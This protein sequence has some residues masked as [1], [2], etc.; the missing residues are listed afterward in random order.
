MQIIPVV[1]SKTNKQKSQPDGVRP[2]VLEKEKFCY[3]EVVSKVRV[4]R[5]L[6]KDAFLPSHLSVGWESEVGPGDRSQ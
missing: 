5:R 3:I 1:Q 6:S 4:P 2:A